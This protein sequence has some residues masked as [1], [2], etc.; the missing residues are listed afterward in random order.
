MGE[1]LL[2]IIAE[3]TIEAPIDTVWE[4]VVGEKTVPVWLGA[5]DYKPLVGTTFFMQ[6][7]PDRRAVHD[8]EGATWCDIE[9]IQ[10]PHKFNFSWYQPG[11][12]P[13]LV[14]I[15]LFSESNQTFVRLMH[16]GWDEYEREAME[17]Y[18]EE[19]T[20][21]WRSDAL[22]ALKRLVESTR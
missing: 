15:S 3:T 17:G 14:Q 4:A 6:E 16:D 9:L 12:P 11:T 7:E 8:T 2:P 19:L 13:T 10:K 5:L 21:Q 18:Y 22:P 20:R 1:P